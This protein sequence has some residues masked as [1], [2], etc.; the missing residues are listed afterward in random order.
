MK[1][2]ESCLD[3]VGR[4]AFR[5]RPEARPRGQKSRRWSAAGRVRLNPGRTPRPKRGL[6][7]A[8]RGAPSPRHK[9]RVE[10]EDGAPR[11]AKNRGG[12]ALACAGC[13]TI[14]SVEE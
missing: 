8:P 14:E 5:P 1:G 11:A 9:R 13:L 10:K 7:G 4:K 2:G 12:G 6:A 3:T